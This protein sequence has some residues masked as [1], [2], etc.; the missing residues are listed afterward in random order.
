MFTFTTGLLPLVVAVANLSAA[1]AAYWRASRGGY[2]RPR[3]DAYGD[4]GRLRWLF[5]MD[6][7]WAEQL[8]HLYNRIQERQGIFIVAAETPPMSVDTSL[9][10]LRS[11]L[12]A[13]QVHRI[14]PLEDEDKVQA[15]VFRAANRG[16]DMPEKVA[17]Y[18]LTHYS[19]NMADQITLLG[20][21]E[22]TSLEVQRKLSIPLVKQVLESEH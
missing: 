14:S 4:S 1:R 12:S 9:A 17:R 16:M 7:A 10:D 13:M 11:R 5:A 18:L 8:F 15:L 6:V 20:K 3:A 21:L 22:L 2:V 19:R